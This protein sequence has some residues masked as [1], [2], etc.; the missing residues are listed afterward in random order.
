MINDK[1][2]EITQ[3]QFEGHAKKLSDDLDKAWEVDERV[4]SL[5]IAIRL[6]NF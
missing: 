2:I 1:K 5:K 3:G 6:R 4:A